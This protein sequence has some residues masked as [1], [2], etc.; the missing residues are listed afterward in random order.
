[1]PFIGGLPLQFLPPELPGYERLPGSNQFAY[2]GG[3][4]TC[5]FSVK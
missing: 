4:F 5:P 3:S 2:G 1:M